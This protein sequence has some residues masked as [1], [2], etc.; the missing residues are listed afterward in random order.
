MDRYKSASVMWNNKRCMGNKHKNKYTWAFDKIK[1]T[2]EHVCLSFEH[3]RKKMEC[4][5][6]QQFVH[7]FYSV[8][9]IPLCIFYYFHFSCLQKRDKMKNHSV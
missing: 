6:K 4:L 7:L 2:F 9:C 8:L 1:T 3:G 5:F